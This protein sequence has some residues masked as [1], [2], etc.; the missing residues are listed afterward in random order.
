MFFFIAVLS[1]TAAPFHPPISLSEVLQELGLSLSQFLDTLKVHGSSLKVFTKK[2]QRK[3]ISKSEF[4]RAKGN[5]KTLLEILESS[6]ERISRSK[7]TKAQQT[8]ITSTTKIEKITTLPPVTTS[9]PTKRLV[10]TTTLRPKT[11]SQLTTE[12]TETT[13]IKVNKEPRIFGSRPSGVSL[14]KLDSEK[15]NSKNKTQNKTSVAKRPIVVELD[16]AKLVKEKGVSAS[17]ILQEFKHMFNISQTNLNLQNKTMKTTPKPINEKTTTKVLRPYRK[18]VE[19][20][21][22]YRPIDYERGNSETHRRLVNHRLSSTDRPT[23]RPPY[24]PLPPSINY[25][26]SVE[27]DFNSNAFNE[28]SKNNQ[29]SSGS[30]L[31]S[32]TNEEVSVS[33]PKYDPKLFNYSIVKSDPDAFDISTRSAIMAAGIL[34]GVALSVFLAIFVV[35]KYRNHTNRHRR[36][37][38]LTLPSDSSSS[39]LPPLYSNRSVTAVT[40]GKEC[41]QTSGF[42][43]SLKKKFDPYSPSSSPT[44]M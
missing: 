6:P 28:K 16:F 44:S 34:G 36:R 32:N 29:N 3:S 12:T 40:Y 27:E 37:I 41:Y 30:S 10:E 1:S 14:T 21:R 18:E 23:L 39:S 13:T 25:G 35:V 38:P 11:T 43:T 42:W 15:P 24:V 9:L 22:P 31:N 2:L 7:V 20:Y 5:V 26:E 8:T 19:R 33:Q 4:R 17:G